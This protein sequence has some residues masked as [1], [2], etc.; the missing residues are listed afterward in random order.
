MD[1]LLFTFTFIACSYALGAFG[2][3]GISIALQITFVALLQYVFYTMTIHP[4]PKFQYFQN[5]V[6]CGKMT[7]Q[8]YV[9]CSKCSVCVPVLY[10]HYESVGMCTSKKKYNRYIVLVRLMILQQMILSCVIAWMYPIVLIIFGLD[11]VL[12]F[13][14]FRWNQTI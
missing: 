5:C 3:D 7:P 9:H 12:L 11:C 6:S 1:H 14:T 10:T 4:P 8:H 2:L 13:M